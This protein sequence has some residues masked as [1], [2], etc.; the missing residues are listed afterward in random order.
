[1][2]VHGI[3]FGLFNCCIVYT[4]S[5]LKRFFFP[6]RSCCVGVLIA[7]AQ[8]LERRLRQSQRRLLRCNT[9]HEWRLDLVRLIVLALSKSYR[10]QSTRVTQTALNILLILSFRWVRRLLS[11]Y[12]WILLLLLLDVFLVAWGVLVFEGITV[13]A[14]LDLPR[15]PMQWKNVLLEALGWMALLHLWGSCNIL[16][17]RSE[18]LYQLL[19]FLIEAA[20][21]DFSGRFR[22]A[23]LALLVV[24][25]GYGSI[26]VAA[27]L[28]GI[29]L[30]VQ[31]S[32]MR[33]DQ[34]WQLLFKLVLETMD[35]GCALK[36][37]L[38]LADHREATLL[39]VVFA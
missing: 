30:L 35:R 19:S 38:T 27:C 20:F 13:G 5:F 29:K 7:N 8:L 32:D 6:F 28:F 23:F 22:Q 2:L 37:R 1:M 16:V 31:H 12:S 26:F 24:D 36:Q 11:C 4:Y 25:L 18:A 15:P 17:I 10:L 3:F 14:T 9:A 33:Q 21:R 34:V 39:S